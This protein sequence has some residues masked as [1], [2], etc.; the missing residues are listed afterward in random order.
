M[1][2]S[3]SDAEILDGCSSD[4]DDVLDDPDPTARRA[5]R[6][7]INSSN[8]GKPFAVLVIGDVSATPSAT[9]AHLLE[10][11]GCSHS[12]APACAASRF[13]IIGALLL[14]WQLAFLDSAL[15]EEETAALFRPACR[16]RQTDT[17][18]LHY[19]VDQHFACAPIGIPFDISQQKFEQFSSIIRAN[20]QVLSFFRAHTIVATFCL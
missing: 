4:C 9:Q 2:S 16:S 1:D 18:Y 10:S 14:H 19:K 12:A 11:I 3:D 15:T 13:F 17:S 8:V 5:V 7:P 6:R 20:P